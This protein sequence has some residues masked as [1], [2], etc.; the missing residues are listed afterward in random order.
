MSCLIKNDGDGEEDDVATRFNLNSRS[1]AAFPNRVANE[2][3]VPLDAQLNAELGAQCQNGDRFPVDVR[4]RV[5]D[6]VVQLLQ[7]QRPSHPKPLQDE[8]LHDGPDLLDRGQVRRVRW[9]AGE[10]MDPVVPEPAHRRY[11]GMASRAVLLEL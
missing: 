1:S 9:P 4:V 10:D 8:P 6:R 2:P 3:A 5:E 7:G 11:R